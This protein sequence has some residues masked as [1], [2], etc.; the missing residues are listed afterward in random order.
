MRIFLVAA[1]VA[2]ALLGRQSA[3]AAEL[4]LLTTG[5]FKPIAQALLPRFE[6]ASGDTVAIENDTAG[7]VL[8]RIQIG[9]AFD[10]V[11]LTPAA[12]RDLE[13]D[14]KL[15][16]GSRTDLAKTGVGVAVKRGAL[17]PDISSVAALK[18]ALLAAKSVAYIDPKSGG[19]SGIYVAQLLQRLGIAKEV[20]AKA[21][22]VPG[23][24]VAERVAKGE[25]QIGIHQ[26][27]EILPVPGVD[28]VGPLPPDIQN[29]TVYAGA[30]SATAQ[31]PDG[32]R[33]LL[34]FLSGPEA[35]AVLREKGMLPP[36][37]TD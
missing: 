34:R 14:G 26:I 36:G 37:G 16:A 10:L 6:A 23:G 8:R 21:V 19:S 13:T 30:L 4:K 17:H 27:S 33:A 24:L 20:E 29:Y 25:A 15:V 35:A 11:V 22:L 9:A 7:G 1:L 18:H 5:A 32:A 3:S 31:Q 2:A 12:L 28:L